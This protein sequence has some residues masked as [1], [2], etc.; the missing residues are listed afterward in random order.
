MSEFGHMRPKIIWVVVAI[1]SA[2]PAATACCVKVGKVSRPAINARKRKG[3]VGNM[4]VTFREAVPTPSG[5]STGIQK[6]DPVSL[7]AIQTLPREGEQFRWKGITY[8]VETVFYDFD[9]NNITL[10]VRR[11]AWRFQGK[12]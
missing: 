10:T 1:V 11:V 5:N 4:M 6:P 9:S 2:G 12:T 3:K 7:S 8:E